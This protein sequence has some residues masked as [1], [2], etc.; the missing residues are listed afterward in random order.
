MERKSFPFE[1]LEVWQ[2]A[3]EI[4]REVY[5]LTTDFPK[6]EM[7]GLTSQIRRA[8][9][10]IANN[11]A[12]GSTRASPKEQAHFTNIAHGSVSELFCSLILASDLQFTSIPQIDPLFKKAYDLSVRLHNLHQSQLNRVAG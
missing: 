1:K 8:A 7:F 5:R 9:V 10:S 12:E 4:V 11:L 6:S 3:R 2:Q